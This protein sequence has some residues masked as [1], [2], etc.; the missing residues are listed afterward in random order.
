MKLTKTALILFTAFLFSSLGSTLLVGQSVRDPHL[1]KALELRDLARSAF[2]A[3]DYDASAELARQA[4]DQLALVQKATAPAPAA[5]VTPVVVPPAA[6]PPAE[7]T[8][9]K[10]ALPAVYTVRLIPEDRDCL[11]KIA[12]YPFVYGDRTKWTILYRAN[13]E[14][15]RHHE[16]ADI[17]LPNEVLVIPSIAGETRVGEY[18]PGKEYPAFNLE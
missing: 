15:L 11:S 14:T 13:R 1:A 17:I 3:G 18:K 10:P 9:D 5:A 6:V 16:N 12:G 4:K 8:A 7:G 2:D